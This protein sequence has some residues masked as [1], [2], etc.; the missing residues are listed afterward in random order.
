MEIIKNINDF[1]LLSYPIISVGRYDGVHKG[2][3]K[4]L[5]RMKNIAQEKQGQI[6]IVTFDP[7]PEEVLFEKSK[8]EI[9]LLNTLDEKAALLEANGVDYL[10]IIPFS[11]SFS[12]TTSFDFVKS[13]LVDLLHVKEYVMGYDNQYGYGRDGDFLLMNKLAQKHR[14]IVNEVPMEDIRKLGV[15]SVRIRKYLSD[16]NIPAANRFLGYKYQ[17]SGVVIKGNQIGH[18][19]GFP[20]AN[21]DVK[22]KY[23]H[24]LMPAG[25]YVVQVKLADNLFYG[26]AN[27]GYRPTI[28]LTKHE[29]TAE[30]NIFRF[31]KNIYGQ[32]ISMCFLEKIRDEQKFD[33]LENLK[34]QLKKDK[35]WAWNVMEREE[36]DF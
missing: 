12:R 1:P 30:V 2:H 26:M 18:Q 25:V 34:L 33:G 13:I 14:F 5:A 15:S 24:K 20:T 17:M 6:V 35:I 11:L 19:L 32:K 16:G 27:I 10:V 7:G 8:D 21:I 28:K 3:L 23:R 9:K 31:Q 29:L 36:Q 4:L 22:E